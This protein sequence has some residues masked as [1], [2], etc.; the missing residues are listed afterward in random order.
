MNAAKEMPNELVFAAN[1]GAPV[2][3]AGLIRKDLPDSFSIYAKRGGAS[4]FEAVIGACRCVS[5][6]VR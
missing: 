3:Y 2:H 4:R 5:I 6:F 1:L